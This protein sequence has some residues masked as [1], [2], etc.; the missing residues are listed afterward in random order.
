MIGIEVETPTI[1][2]RRGCNAGADYSAVTL[3]VLG[4]KP[5]TSKSP[6]HIAVCGLFSR[7]AAS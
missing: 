6:S 7:H 4:N 5:F 1:M 3:Q 2:K